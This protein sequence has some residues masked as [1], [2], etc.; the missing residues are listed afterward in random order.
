VRAEIILPGRPVPKKNH[1]RIVRRGARPKLL[2]SEA[3]ERYET[4]CLWRLKTYRGPRF[5]GPVHLRA[6][7]WLPNRKWWP[8]LAGLIQAT[9]DI[10]QAAE[11]LDDDKHVV[12]LDGSEIAGLDKANPRAE[13]TIEEWKDGRDGKGDAGRG[14]GGVGTDCAERVLP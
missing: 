9:Q 8:D 1:G 6:R 11:I 13:I 3:Y 10:L 12:L 2:P 7:Y 5:S 14:G 4:E